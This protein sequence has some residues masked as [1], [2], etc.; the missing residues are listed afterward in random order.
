MIN[1]EP[2]SSR[3]KETDQIG[4]IPGMQGWFNVNKS[5]DVIH[6]INKS[7][8]EEPTLI[9]VDAEKGCDKI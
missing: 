6:H 3:K 9:S 5:M 2:A 7:K 8:S 4:F 1:S